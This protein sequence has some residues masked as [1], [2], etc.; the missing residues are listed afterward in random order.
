MCSLISSICAP[1]HAHAARYVTQNC[2]P[3]YVNHKA[4]IVY[5]LKNAEQYAGF[6][7]SF[8]QISKQSRHELPSSKMVLLTPVMVDAQGLPEFA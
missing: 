3:L 7:P 1:T 6:F 5:F 2:E 4:S 8:P